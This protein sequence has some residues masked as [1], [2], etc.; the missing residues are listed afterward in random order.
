MQV[1][2]VL[3]SINFKNRFNEEQ[4]RPN[5]A[6]IQPSFFVNP[7]G[8]GNNE[9]VRA[10]SSL[11]RSLENMY[12]CEKSKETSRDLSLERINE[13]IERMQELEDEKIAIFKQ[14][15]DKQNNYYTQY[16]K[17]A[18]LKHSGVEFQKIKSAYVL[19]QEEYNILF[20]KLHNIQKKINDE[21]GISSDVVAKPS[22]TR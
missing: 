16:S 20:D 18:S 4:T 3:Q 2:S 15:E 11:M 14:L 1:Q 7:L 6:R 10:D 22:N 5:Q 12:D 9:E 21:L 19:Q 17:L 8:D 13:Q